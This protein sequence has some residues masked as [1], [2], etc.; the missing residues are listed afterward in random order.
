MRKTE[1]RKNK[2]SEKQDRKERVGET[3]RMST[4]RKTVRTYF[5]RLFEIIRKVLKFK[6]INLLKIILNN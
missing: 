4:D 5:L 1:K 3:D 2:L 6:Q